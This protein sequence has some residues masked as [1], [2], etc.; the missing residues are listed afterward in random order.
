VCG[1]VDFEVHVLQHLEIV[2]ALDILVSLVAFWA[3]ARCNCFGIFRKVREEI[4]KRHDANGTNAWIGLPYSY[5]KAILL[6]G[7]GFSPVP[8]VF[9]WSFN[10]R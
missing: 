8:G 3:L 10:R 2:R 6:P 1:Y 7:A 4:D 5:H 9:V